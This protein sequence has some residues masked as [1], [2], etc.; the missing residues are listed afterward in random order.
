MTRES[1]LELKV[2]SFVLAG[3]VV[4]SFFVSSISNFSFVE[5]GW[6]FQ[7]VFTFANGIKDAAPVRL[8]G[9]DVGIVKGI[10]IYTDAQDKH[11]KVRINCW[12][13]E[14]VNIPIDSKVMINQLGLLGEKY[15]EII[16]GQ[17]AEFIK[18]NAVIFGKDPVPVERV[19]EQ[20]NEIADKISL[21]IDKVNNELLSQANRDAVTGAL[22]GIN[23]LITKVNHGEGTIGRLF[24][25]DSIYRNLDELTMDLKVNPWKLLYRPRNTK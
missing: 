13:K 8:A 9:T 2:G 19:T 15:V 11:I 10:K 23:E 16:P 6:P 24:N 20:V 12:V 25:D 21:T 14:G 22:K 5:K 4:M 7:A 1:H 18:A 17:S 3:L